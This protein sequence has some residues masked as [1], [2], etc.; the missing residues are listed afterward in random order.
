[1]SVAQDG[2]RLRVPLQLLL[3]TFASFTS[4]QSSATSRPPQKADSIANISQP[5][6]Q[7]FV[8]FGIEPTNLFSFTGSDTSNAFS[9]QLF[10]NLADYSGSPPHIR[11]GGNTQDYMVYDSTYDAYFVATN[12]NPKGQ[13]AIPSDLHTFGP[14]FWEV[15]DRFPAQTPV[16]FGLN[17]AYEASDWPQ[18]VVNSAQ[19]AVSNIKN[20]KL[21]SFEIGNEP[22]LYHN[23][24]FRPTSYV[25]SDY[26]TDWTLRAD[27]VWTNVL[28]PN[29][30]PSAFFEPGATASTIGTT[31][32]IEKLA[33]GG[34]LSGS[35]GAGSFVSSWNQHDYFYFVDVSTYGLTLQGL[36]QLSKTEDQFTAW[37]GQVKQAANTNLPYNLRE[38]ASAGPVG[39]KTIT[40][41]FGAALWTL[42]FFCYAASLGI[43]S[44]QMHMTDNSFAS[45]WAPIEQQG[46]APHV[47]PSY[48]AFAAM[49]QLIGT[50]NGTLQ[51]T[52]L[53][54]E[55]ISS[56][57]KDYVRAYSFYNNGDLAGVVIINGKIAN[58]TTSAS[59]RVGINLN[60]VLDGVG[61]QKLWLQTLT[62]KGADS[63][64]GATWNGI[65]FDS[66]G[67]GTP[68]Q[69]S[70]TTDVV[71]IT[72]DGKAAFVVNDSQAIIAT[73]NFQIGG[74]KSAKQRSAASSIWGGSI[75]AAVI[76]G[77]VTSLWMLFES[78]GI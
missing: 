54:L 43:A 59:A 25:A 55:G 29:G 38:M 2:F 8:G 66:N 7:S 36:Q 71:D 78:F 10:Q 5:L 6:S 13:G 52:N 15:I 73:I 57:Y 26:I 61:G 69:T 70:S 50:G 58:S 48:A 64:S 34:I 21:V 51:I 40:D 68:K 17:L 75:R 65:S 11:L 28:A 41:T 4:A 62:A 19:A 22:D 16:T 1:M 47:R 56:D 24:G 18:R 72:N 63:T 74:A 14:K 9:L 67:D 20:A 32:E 37:A 31:F 42:N 76:G 23:N 27:A 3:L 30:M 44:V 53:N 46:V 77:I 35:S 12:P 60:L 33:A 49:A 45:P 39:I